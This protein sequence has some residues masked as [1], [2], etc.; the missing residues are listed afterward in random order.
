[1]L[2]LKSY[3]INLVR[4]KKRLQQFE[5][6][7]RP[8]LGDSLE[9]VEAIDRRDIQASECLTD[10]QLACLR[11]HMKT[12]NRAL[13]TEFDYFVIFEDDAIPEY[14]NVLEILEM[15]YQKTKC[16]IIHCC[17]KKHFY[18]IESIKTDEIVIV[19]GMPPEGAFMV[20]YTRTGINQY[21]STFSSERYPADWFRKLDLDVKT[22]V[23]IPPLAT[24]INEYSYISTNYGRR[25]L[26]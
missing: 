24:H 7:W 3:C 9:Y 20:F 12:M 25:F 23:I 6:Q 17:L 11:S 5:E 18:N 16:D 13:E 19:N 10:G 14:E 22:C 21:L 26:P 2:K 4:A 15:V 1:M 8:I